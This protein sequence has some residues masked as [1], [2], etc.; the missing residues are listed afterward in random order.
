VKFKPLL[1]IDIGDGSHTLSVRYT[2]TSFCVCFVHLEF[3]YC[4]GS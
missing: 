4:I 1:K 2:V 3:F